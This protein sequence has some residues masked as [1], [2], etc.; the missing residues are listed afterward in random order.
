[1]K[2][3]ILVFAAMAITA[4]AYA[5]ADSTKRK[6]N[7]VDSIRTTDS[8]YQNRDLNKNPNR[9]KTNPDTLMN[10]Q[11][12]QL[13]YA[14]GVLMLSGKMMKVKDCTMTPLEQNLT[15]SNGT[16]VSCEG[17]YVKKDG[18]EMTFKDGEHIDMSG[19]LI[20]TKNL[21]SKNK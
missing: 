15:M 8:L 5:Q 18:T 7:P 14:D 19:N 2:K 6:M 11:P 10:D 16:K 1:M 13:A 20:S 3:L 9:D 12:Q 17:S 4:G 21:T